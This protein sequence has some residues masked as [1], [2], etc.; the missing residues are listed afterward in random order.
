MHLEHT[1][2]SI[3]ED[4][5]LNDTRTTILAERQPNVAK[6]DLRNIFEHIVSSQLRKVT[7]Y[8]DSP[9]AEIDVHLCPRPYLE[10]ISPIFKPIVSL[11]W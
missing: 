2:I 8:I 6:N 4:S 9:I 11:F 10:I 1:K 7:G 5:K 3:A